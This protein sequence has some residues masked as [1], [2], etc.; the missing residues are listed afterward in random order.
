MNNQINI[1]FF[2]YS[3]IFK[4]DEEKFVEI[5][6]TVSRKGG[7]ILQSELNEFEKNAADFISAKHLIGVANG[8]DAIWLGLIAAG[9]EKNDEIIM[10]SHTYI[11]SPAAVNFV[12]A[13][14]ILADCGQDNM[15][16][17][18]D[19]ERHITDKTRA[20]MPVQ[21]NGRCCDMK[22]ILEIA[23]RNNLLVIEDAAQAFGAKYNDKYAGTF[24]LFGTI[25]FYPAKLLGCFG[26]GGALVT[27]DD[28]L[29]QKVRLLRD[30]GRNEY[31]EVVTW[32]FNSRLD[33]LQAAFLDEKLKTYPQ[34]IHR[35]RKIAL[36]YN[37]GLKNNKSLKLPPPPDKDLSYFD[38]FQNYEMQAEDRDLLKRYLDDNGIKTIVQWA[39]TPVHQFS[40][41]G[42]NNTDLHK[43]DNFF[44]KCL[45]FPMNTSLTD[46]EVFYIIEKINEF[47]GNV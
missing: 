25:S 16:D 2:N 17:P 10:P 33:N 13:K 43:T 19:I 40:K 6:R 20:I 12:G 34:D 46:N 44:K 27:N 3:D 24:G 28:D 38:V 21:I 31:G 42:F 4:K 8:T 7:F 15:L 32:G 29:A 11:A 18:N 39:G 26:D 36:I 37:D 35:R 9:I 30:H 22:K 41:L 5:F 14:A 23:K 45:M 47:Y 1:P